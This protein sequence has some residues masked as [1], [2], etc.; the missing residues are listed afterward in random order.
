MGLK[1]QNTLDEFS[2]IA[3]RSVITSYILA[4]TD[5]LSQRTAVS[6]HWARFGITF[7]G[8]IFKFHLDGTMMRGW[9]GVKSAWLSLTGFTKQICNFV[10][11]NFFFRGFHPWAGLSRARDEAP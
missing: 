9:H 5:D 10:T 1:S 11:V 8:F 3:M 4:I 7:A 6:R 2:V